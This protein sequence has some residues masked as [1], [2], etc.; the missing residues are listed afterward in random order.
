[1]ETMPTSGEPVL[2]TH[3]LGTVVGMDLLTRLTDDIDPVLLVTAGSPLGLDGVN[4][5]L[6]TRGPHQPP[7][8]VTG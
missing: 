8:C 2:V 4:E 1:M 6:L 3:S 5:R 7:G